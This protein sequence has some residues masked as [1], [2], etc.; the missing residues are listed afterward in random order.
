MHDLTPTTAL[1]GMA[2]VATT[3]GCLTIAEN[4]RLSLASVAARLG[5][6]EA[7]K[8]ALKTLIGDVPGPGRAQL[9]TPEMAFW[10]GP[11]QWMVTA[12]SDTHAVLAD[13]VKELVGSTASV[14]EQTGAWV[15]FDVTG[16]GMMDLSE[17]ICA[18]PI[19]TMQA[20]DARRTLIHQL[21]C[22]VIRHDADDHIRIFG[23]R[24]SAHS[25]HH[26]LVT[27]AQAVT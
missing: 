12:Q 25:L 13:H 4:D 10:I 2:P 18:I 8:D 5:K 6:A 27:A 3:I 23:P 16:A 14:T 22:F 19:R 11:D 21:S 26:T 7:C 15:C 24:A 9:Y 1:G 17:R 20:G